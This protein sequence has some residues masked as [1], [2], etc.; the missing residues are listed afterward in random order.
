MTVGWTNRRNGEGIWE[1]GGRPQKY[2][3]YNRERR[4]IEMFF[5]I[6]FDRL[7]TNNNLPS[8]LMECAV[9]KNIYVVITLKQ[10]VFVKV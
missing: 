1:K 9:G 5:P 10:Q 3:S 6:I 4:M 2:R 8:K 7:C